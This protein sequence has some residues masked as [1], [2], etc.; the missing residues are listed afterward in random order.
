ME[1]I[2]VDDRT[3]VCKDVYI[4]FIFLL[5]ANMQKK[6]SMKRSNEK[7][8]DEDGTVK[9]MKEEEEESKRINIIN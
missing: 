2:Q 9:K 5:Q 1:T 8:G 7:H 4:S 6:R 3:L